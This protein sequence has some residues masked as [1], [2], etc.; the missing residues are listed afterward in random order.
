MTCLYQLFSQRDIPSKVVDVDILDDNSPVILTSDGALRF[1]DKTLSQQVSPIS[2]CMLKTIFCPGLLPSA[3][4]ESLKVLLMDAKM[5]EGVSPVNLAHYRLVLSRSSLSDIERQ[6]MLAQLHA[7]NADDFNHLSSPQCDS[8]AERG[9]FVSKLF[10]DQYECD[11]WSLARFY[12]GKEG[13]PTDSISSRFDVL[14]DTVTF[15]K[16]ELLHC[17]VFDAKRATYDQLVG[18]IGKLVLL[19]KHDQAVQLLLDTDATHPQYLTDNLKACLISAVHNSSEYQST[20]KLVATNLIA[21]GKMADGVQLLSL[22]D[23]NVDACRYM[24]SY[25]EWYQ[26]AWLAKVR[27]SDL[28]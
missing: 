25:G 11:L 18:H 28:Y 24:Q 1:F 16:N 22:I 21:S 2:H 13:N 9:L 7:L 3:L 15:R 14:C 12:L 23:L 6:L 5:R 26:A 10:G 19:K 4:R 17:A 20:M 8:M 27:S